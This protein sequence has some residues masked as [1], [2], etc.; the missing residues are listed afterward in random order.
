M[1]RKF[2]GLLTFAFVTSP[3]TIAGTC[4][5]PSFLPSYQIYASLT[6]GP[7]GNPMTPVKG[8][9]GAD[10]DGD[11]KTD[12]AIAAGDGLWIAIWSPPTNKNYPGSKRLTTAAHT[13]DFVQIADVNH[14]TVPDVVFTSRTSGLVTTLLGNGD[15]TFRELSVPLVEAWQIAIGDFNGDGKPDLAVASNTPK[16]LNVFLGNGDGTYRSPVVTTV[17]ALPTGIAV[18]DLNGDGKLDVALSYATEAQIDVLLGNGDGS[19]QTA[20]IG[21]LPGTGGTLAA[22]DIDGDGRPDLIVPITNNYEIVIL[23]NIG[24]GAF[25]TP[26]AITTP[27]TVAD[28]LPQ[29]LNPKPSLVT[30]GDFMRRGRPDIAVASLGEFLTIFP[31]NGDGTY[32]DPVGIVMPGISPAG[33]ASLDVDADGR[34]DVAI[35]NFNFTGGV[36][37]V[38]NVCGA[39]TIQA[40]SKYATLSA[41]QQT[42]ITAKVLGYGGQATGSVS[43]MEG[44]QTLRT[45]ALAAGQATFAGVALPLGEHTLTV[46]Y[47][48][49]AEFDPNTSAPIPLHVVSATTATTLIANTTHTVYPD[50][51]QI[52]ASVRS[53]TGDKPT[54][55]FTL[56]I[57]GTQDPRGSVSVDG[58]TSLR[59]TAGTYVLVA[60]YDGDGTHPP[61]TSAPITVAIDQAPATMTASLHEAPA[62][63]QP[64]HLFVTVT[65]T[66]ALT[67]RI[68]VSEN[69]SPRGEA[70]SESLSLG[71]SI[72]AGVLPPGAH[73]LLVTYA[74]DAN[75]RTVSQTVTLTVPGTPPPPK[76][77]AAPHS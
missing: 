1:F 29:P 33:I 64:L 16:S 22:A 48:G 45:A 47:G 70:T 56:L 66:T 42:S 57:D 18:T 61:S 41:G 23:R 60:S 7:S 24:G 13:A 43:L 2:I 62:A 27:K 75:V 52:S 77:R 20:T 5:A 14:D 36:E 72:S 12:F 74:A 76:R 58:Y 53:S 67:G 39:T 38:A 63:G 69:A 37:V 9:A 6:P 54:G 4:A 10:L 49:D 44:N 21:P 17:S 68:F 34:T 50:T 31:S 15:G 30:T 19:F 8:I 71:A 26:V 35:G 73:T 65:S 55:T 46:A 32:G 28:Y 40:A 3:A 51:P 59:T 25:A 11:G